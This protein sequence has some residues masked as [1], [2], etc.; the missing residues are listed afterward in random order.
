MH[1]STP[2][3]PPDWTIEVGQNIHIHAWNVD[4]EQHNIRCSSHDLLCSICLIVSGEAV[5]LLGKDE[6][7][8]IKSPGICFIDCEQEEL[9]IKSSEGGGRLRFVGIDILAGGGVEIN[10]V[11]TEIFKKYC[12]RQNINVPSWLN[13]S[14]EKEP[15]ISQAMQMFLCP[16]QGVQ[17][18]LYLSGLA[19]QMIASM[20]NYGV[21]DDK[22][23]GLKCTVS[24]Q[25]AESIDLVRC[26]LKDRCAEPPALSELARAA[27]LSSR[28]LTTLFQQVTGSSIPEF[29]R[30]YRL[31]RAFCL[32]I[33]TKLQVAQ[34]A[35]KIGY[36]PAHLATSFKKR[37]GQTPNTIRKGEFGK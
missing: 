8:Q 30:E 18:E 23:L 33:H 9:E 14:V 4:N 19:L 13:Q 28:R 5:F 25:D 32:L 24:P 6:E 12:R 37:F 7:I 29:L 31:Q 20:M 2:S 1:P 3:L 15:L 21:T 35:Y 10:P 26:M 36:T 16:L 22:F 27:G 34:I 11:N 17:R